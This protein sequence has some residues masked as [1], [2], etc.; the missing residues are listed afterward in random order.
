MALKAY[1][2]ATLRQFRFFFAF[3]GFI[4]D[5]HRAWQLPLKILFNGSI[6][7]NR[8]DVFFFHTFVFTFVSAVT[9]FFN[10]CGNR[11]RSELQKKFNK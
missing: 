5:T 8:F 9:A 3:F 2:S 11:A 10:I 6:L 1:I 4:V 7:D